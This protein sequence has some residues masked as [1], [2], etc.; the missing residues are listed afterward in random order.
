MCSW[1]G[2]ERADFGD[3][4]Y[5]HVAGIAGRPLAIRIE[6]T[7]R[8]ALRPMAAEM[9]GAI[10]GTQVKF[11]HAPPD[12]LIVDAAR[13]AARADVAL[14]FVGHKVGEGMD[15]T[16]LALPNDQDALI[17]A[18]ARANPRT[19]VVLN[20]G[21]PVSMP[22]L[23]RVAAVLEMWLP[24]D[25]Y[26]PAAARLLFGDADPAGRLPVT[27]PRDESQGPATMPHQYPGTL[28]SEGRLDT[29]WFDEGIFVGYRFWDQHRQQ[30]LFPFGH[31]LSY[32]RFQV[33]AP[34]LE[35]VAGGGARIA[36]RVRNISGRRGA[37]VLQAYVGFPDSAGAPPLQLKGVA[38]LW[39]DAGEEREA[40]IELD[41]AA[42]RFWDESRNGW[43]RAEGDY[44]VALGRS[45]RDIFWQQ[46]FRPAN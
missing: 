16:S 14:V 41:A 28:D 30:P 13:A 31:G 43:R 26:G 24:G 20:T 40:V 25:A 22:W 39:L 12:T 18:V 4:V 8:A 44:T 3:A 1:A 7:P 29:A 42:L 32:A 10:G 15:R 37:E 38:K 35:P 19:V 34:R 11:G 36:V 45:S 21:G 9:F 46:A 27:F 2:I 33:Q 17:E 5:A 6:Y 23:G